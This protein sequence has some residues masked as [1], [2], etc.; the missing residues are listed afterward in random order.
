MLKKLTNLTIRAF[1]QLREVTFHD[2]GSVNLLVGDNSSG[3]T[4]VLE[5]IALFCRPLDPL[6]LINT[7]RRR[8]IKSSRERLL[9]GIQWLFPQNSTKPGEPYFHGSI[10]FSGEGLLQSK[11]NIEFVG[12][13]GDAVSDGSYEIIEQD[14]LSAMSTS[15]PDDSRRGAQISMQCQT[16]QRLLTGEYECLHHKF[17]IWEDERYVSRAPVDARQLPVATISPVAH[18]VELIQTKQLSEAVLDHKKFSIIEALRLIDDD[19][20]NLEIVSRSGISPTLWVHHKRAGFSPVSTLGDGTRRVLSLALQLHSVRGGILLID[21]LETAIHK[22]ALGRVFQWL[23]GACKYFDVQLFATTHSL[24]AIDALLTAEIA[25][26][27][28]LV[29]FQLPERGKTNVKRFDGDILENLRF[30]RGLDI[31]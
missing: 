17:E 25:A 31:R 18:R 19:I 3:K 5:S 2:C 22:D 26:P 6:E 21:E 23:V 9:D 30:E 1:R 24:E 20:D 16:N 27:V 12:L 7:A 11:V 10:S 15:D 28:D 8:E 14:D 13:L 29:A 4:S